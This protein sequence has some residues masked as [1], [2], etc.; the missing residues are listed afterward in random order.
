MC[1]DLQILLL[2][3]LSLHLMFWSQFAI[4]ILL[5]SGPKGPP[6][7]ERG[8]GSETLKCTLFTVIASFYHHLPLS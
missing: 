7:L 3:H 6:P 5:P 1:L 2:F 4:C 8:S